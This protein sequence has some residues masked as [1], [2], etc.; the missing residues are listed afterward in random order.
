MKH[1]IENHLWHDS[2][3]KCKLSIQ[4]L[5][6]FCGNRWD[7]IC[8]EYHNFGTGGAKKKKKIVNNNVP[9]AQ[10]KR[11]GEIRQHQ[12]EAFCSDMAVLT[13]VLCND[14]GLGEKKG[15]QLLWRER[16]RGCNRW[17]WVVRIGVR[18]R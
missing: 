17:G 3:Q 12:R 16:E 1:G 14:G 4:I 15:R 6:L 7:T 2:H 13:Q 9:L 8:I 5:S 10:M 18:K 11:W